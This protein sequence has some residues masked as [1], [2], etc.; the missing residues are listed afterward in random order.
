MSD[1]RQP[2]DAGLPD[3]DDIDTGE[4]IRALAE[5]DHPTSSGFLDRVRLKIERRSVGNQ[6]AAFSWHVP[7]ILLLEFL[8]LVFHLFGQQN[9]DGGNE[10]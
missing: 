8:E 3:P 7:K 5:L 4:P 6:F 1:E 9:D 2:G 10:P